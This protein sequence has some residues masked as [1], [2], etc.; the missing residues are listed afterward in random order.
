MFDP[1]AM[2]L[3]HDL[4]ILDRFD[5]GDRQAGRDRKVVKAVSSLQGVRPSG[6]PRLLSEACDPF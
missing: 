4:P 3:G 5:L 6:T 2:T 1:L